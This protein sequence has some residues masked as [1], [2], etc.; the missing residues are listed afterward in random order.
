MRATD[1]PKNLQTSRHDDLP[2]TLQQAFD[3]FEGLLVTF[4]D[5]ITKD[6][7]GFFV[8]MPLWIGDHQRDAA[9]LQFLISE[10]RKNINAGHYSAQEGIRW[11]NRLLDLMKKE[12]ALYQVLADIRKE[13]KTELQNMQQGKKAFKGYMSETAGQRPAFLSQDA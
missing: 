5:A 6:P 9:I 1:V 10:L 7:Q 13:I 3:K 4:T 12:D 11:Q 8:K 2:E